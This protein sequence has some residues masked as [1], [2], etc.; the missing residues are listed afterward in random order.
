MFLR[1]WKRGEREPKWHS[2]KMSRIVPVGVKSDTLPP[3][4]EGRMNDRII[5]IVWSISK[6]AQACCSEMLSKFSLQGV[7]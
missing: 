3:S 2:F 1:W 6:L 7:I 4:R 5:V